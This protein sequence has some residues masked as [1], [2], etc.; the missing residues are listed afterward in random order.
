MSKTENGGVSQQLDTY[1]TWLAYRRIIGN[2]FVRIPEM[3]ITKMPN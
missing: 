2:K 1:I 3:A